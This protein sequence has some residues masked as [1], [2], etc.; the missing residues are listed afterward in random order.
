M[1]RDTI[2]TRVVAK[3]FLLLFAVFVQPHLLIYCMKVLFQVDWSHEYWAVLLFM[4]VFRSTVRPVL[5][6]EWNE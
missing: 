6:K 3:L 2:E 4:L 1:S 5:P